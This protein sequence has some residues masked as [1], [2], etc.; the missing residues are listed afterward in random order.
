MVLNHIESLVLKLGFC[1][2]EWAK[3]EGMILRD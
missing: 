2:D 3:K 1:V